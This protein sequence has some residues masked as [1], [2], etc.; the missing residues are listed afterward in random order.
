MVE[1]QAN[2][3]GA[4]RAVT[5]P[6]QADFVADL[7]EGGNS[8]CGASLPAFVNL[9]KK[10]GYRLV[11]VERYGFNAFF[12]RDDIDSPHFPEKSAEECLR[13]VFK[14]FVQMPPGP[15]FLNRPWVEV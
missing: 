5:M 10:K 1:C 3:W 11:G 14:T 9:G 7:S 8:Y 2:N 6:Y 13:K 12:I 4:E 15:S